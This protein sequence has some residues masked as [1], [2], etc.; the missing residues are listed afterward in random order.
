MLVG[1]ASPNPSFPQNIKNVTG[2]NNVV[3][4]S[5]NIWKPY[6]YSRS[7]GG[8]DWVTSTDGTITAN[9][10]A[11]GNSY[12]ANATT[13]LDY[14]Y[15]LKAG[16]Y[17]LSGA[18]ENVDIQLINT[19]TSTAIAAATSSTPATFTLEEDTNVQIVTLLTVTPVVTLVLI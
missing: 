7:N 9:G 4:N 12:N 13:L 5:K 1:T 14:V 6:N 19:A 8:I 10:K 18:I 2:N 3:V 16:T 17:T 11:T 15:T